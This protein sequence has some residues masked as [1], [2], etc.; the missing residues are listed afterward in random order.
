MINADGTNLHKVDLSV[1]RVAAP[2]WSPD[3]T[4]LVFT[5][6]IDYSMEAAN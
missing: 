5:S 6:D 3:G 4:T 1:P 2:Q